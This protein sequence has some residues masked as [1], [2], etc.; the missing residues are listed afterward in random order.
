MNILVI[1]GGIGGLAAAAALARQGHTVDVA[2]QTTAFADVGAGIVIQANAHAVLAALGISLRPED[3]TPLGL[4]Q[5]QSQARGVLGQT[6]ADQFGIRPLSVSIHRADLHQSLTDAAEAAGARIQLGQR[7]A[8][9]SADDSGVTAT[10]S[11]GLEGRWELAVGADGLRSVTR[12]L[13]LGPDAGAPR[14]AGQTCW[15]LVATV[16]DALRSPGVE[17]WS[18][19]GMHRIGIVPLSRG[20]V[21]V[22]L[23]ARAPEGTPGPDTGEVAAL[24]PRFGPLEPRMPGILAAAPPDRPLHH[25]DLYDQPRV[26]FGRGRVVLVGDAGHAVTPNMGQGAG[27]AIEDAAML[28]ILLREGVAPGALPE[29]ML[30]ARGARVQSVLQTSW[31]IGQAAHLGWGPGRGLRDHAMQL[32]PASAAERQARALWQP[33]I[34]LAAR[35]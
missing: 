16:P 23:V 3:T 33:G 9:L 30:K 6:A 31:R 18:A 14:Y 4:F 1:G 26:S 2:E 7:L 29:A 21:Y 13:L 5:I 32:L 25:G 27:M 17:L 24:L 35:V 12:T 20:R 34:D 11:G 15:R 19:D 28:S 8:A 10:F 22:F